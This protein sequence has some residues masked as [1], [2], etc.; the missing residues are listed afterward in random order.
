MP[1]RYQERP[2]AA[3]VQSS[4]SNFVD[5][6]RIRAYARRVAARIPA[7][8]ARDRFVRVTLDVLR[9]DPRNARPLEPIEWAEAPDWALRE[10]MSGRAVH[11]FAPNRDAVAPLR[12]AAGALKETCAE[13]AFYE[14][15]PKRTL[16]PRDRVIWQLAR[17]FL[18]KIQ[19]MSFDAIAEK[20]ERFKAERG[21]RL[22]AL[23]DDEILFVREEIY[24]AP[25]RGWR[26]VCSVGE[27][28]NLGIELGNC[29]ERT[30]RQHP[31]FARRL[32]ADTARFWVLRDTN[33]VALMAA[34]TCPVTGRI[35]DVRGPRNVGVAPDNADLS[36]LIEARGR[37]HWSLRHWTQ[38]E[39]LS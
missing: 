23:R 27:L 3:Q 29:L 5:E 30:S 13:L 24:T 33:G 8:A 9:A 19:R 15:A 39:P 37:R 17:E 4:A 26:R 7:S 22:A 21:R 10:H 2:P 31:G 6:G 1:K 35:I 11:A 32:R 12:S 18:S 25:G 34:M 20:A 14:G 38:G 28:S 16:T 36:S